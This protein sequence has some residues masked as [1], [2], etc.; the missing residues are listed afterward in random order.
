MPLMTQENI[1]IVVMIQHMIYAEAEHPCGVGPA[2][3]AV[4]GAQMAPHLPQPLFCS[5]MEQFQ[6]QG[7]WR[8]N[9]GG[10]EEAQGA[11]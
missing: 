1:S 6:T 9:S 11:Q 4:G 7:M 3:D 2:M 10:M 8:G 5:K